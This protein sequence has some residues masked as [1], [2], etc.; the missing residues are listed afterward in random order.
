[1]SD[2]KQ[3]DIVR[4]DPFI[5]MVERVAANPDIDADKIQKILDMQIQV[6]DRTARDEFY[7]AFNRVQANLPAIVHD[8]VNPQ[9]SS[10]YAKLKTVSAALKP[11]YTSEGFS[12]SFGTAD[13]PIEGWTRIEGVLRHVGGH[14]ETYHVDLPL[15]DVGIKG[16]KNKTALHGAKSTLTYGQRTLTCLIFDVATGEDTDGNL[17]QESI[18]T[19][20]ATVI[21]DLIKETKAN[22]AKFLNWAGV[23]KV[24]DLPANLYQQAKQSLEDR[25]GKD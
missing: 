4:P 22:K 24:E 17:P 6:M 19:D 18:T 2:D 13:S 8:A 7:A 16:S 21:N 14:A 11:V 20:Q 25:R 9:T 10:S 12:T 3:V 1:M 23:E 15:D 5:E